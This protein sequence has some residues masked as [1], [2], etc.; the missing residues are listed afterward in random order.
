MVDHF[1][2]SFS[3]PFDVFSIIWEEN[4]SDLQVQRIFL[5]DP[6][7]KSETKTFVAFKTI[8]SGSSSVINSLGNKILKFLEGEKIDFDLQLIGFDQC[9]EIQNKVLLAEYDIPR[10]WVS[11]YKRIA[12]KIGIPK[13][14]RAVGNALARNPF[15]IVIPCH[16]AIKSNGELG[17]FQGGIEMKRTLLEMEGIEFSNRGKVI[18][19][20]IYY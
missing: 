6:E 10:G 8:E 3:S 5:T 13:G 14:A 17:G 12:D 15:P 4:D 2:T 11:T 1:Y 20:K 7:I 16:R 18:T 19:N 9:L